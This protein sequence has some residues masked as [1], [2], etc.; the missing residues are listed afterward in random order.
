MIVE[1]INLFDPNSIEEEIEMRRE[2]EISIPDGADVTVLQNVNRALRGFPGK[3]PVV[4]FLQS[5][6]VTR[7][8]DLPFSIDPNQ[9]VQDLIDDLLG[10]GS[11][12]IV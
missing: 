11:F 3:M 12:K 1:N 2:V 5:K 8:M 4:L 10:P 6:G 9:T 7:R